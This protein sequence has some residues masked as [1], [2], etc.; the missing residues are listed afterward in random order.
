MKQAKTQ[1]KKKRKTE[2]NLKTHRQITR[3]SG[4]QVIIAQLQGSTESSSQLFNTPYGSC[5]A[6][7]ILIKASTAR[8]KQAN[9]FQI[10]KSTKKHTM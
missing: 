3:L 5:N 1:K 4:E 8:Q 2:E 7:L 6:S 10:L 9:N